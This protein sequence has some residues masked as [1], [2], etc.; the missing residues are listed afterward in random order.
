MAGGV[1]LNI[2]AASIVIIAEPQLKPSIEVQAI[3]RSYR[4]GQVNDV[5][6]YRLLTEKS[7][8]ESLVELLNHK[9][10]IFDAYAKESYLA[11]NSKEAKDISEVNIQKVILSK[12]RARISNENVP[13]TDISA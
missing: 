7:I 8:D 5:M 2:Q 1:G 12:E 3:S 13:E 4:M 10:A 9:Q 11:D 6:V